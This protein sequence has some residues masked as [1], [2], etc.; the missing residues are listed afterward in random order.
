MRERAITFGNEMSLVGVLTEPDVSKRLKDA[1]CVLMLNAGILHHVGP[2]RLHV[3]MARCLAEQGYMSFRLDL[4]G[5]GDSLSVKD[6]DYDEDSIID[7]VRMAIDELERKKEITNFVIMGLCTGA[8][9]A[10]KV[11]VADGRVKSAAFLGGY[12]YPTWRFYVKRYLPKI[13]NP[14]RVMNLL[15]RMVPR[16]LRKPASDNQS[17]EMPD[18][19]GWWNLPPK[20]KVYGDLVKLVDRGVDLLY[21]YSGDESEVYNY[22]DQFQQ[23]FS[24]IE[25]NGKLKVIINEEADHTYIMAEDRDR[26]ISQITSW[27]NKCY[28]Q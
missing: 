4:N 12:A 28:R 11:A 26:L 17:L 16:V 13:I 27:L 10:H 3:D 21:I 8:A 7:D 19:F 6:A 14:L 15:L 24:S 23:A 1:P 20:N 25:F 18:D 5:I 2:F 9:N 22:Q